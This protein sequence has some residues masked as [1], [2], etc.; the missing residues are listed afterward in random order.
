MKRFRFW[1]FITQVPLFVLA[2]GENLDYRVWHFRHFIL[3]STVVW[4]I[5][6]LATSPSIGLKRFRPKPATCAKSQVDAK[7]QAVCR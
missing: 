1:L 7:W 5:V 2:C 3:G 4:L 6:A